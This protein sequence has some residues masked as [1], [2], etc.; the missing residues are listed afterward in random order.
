MKP[1]ALVAVLALSAC[2]MPVSDQGQGQGGSID[3]AP[4]VNVT[5][6]FNGDVKV[7]GTLTPTAAP[8]AASSA[9]SDQAA[10]N[11]VKPNVEIPAS[12]I[13]TIGAAGTIVPPVV[14]PAT[15]EPP[16]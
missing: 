10:T 7:D 11:D 9:K 14:V 4:V 15:P 13:P 12:A 1:L 16:R 8:S 6:S 3:R 5:V 2:A